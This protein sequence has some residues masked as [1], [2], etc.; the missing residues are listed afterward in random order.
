VDD[1]DYSERLASIARIVEVLTDRLAADQRERSW[2][3]GATASGSAAAPSPALINE[4][5][6]LAVRLLRDL[7]DG[8]SDL[9][10]A[11]RRLT[12]DASTTSGLASAAAVVTS[13]ACD[14]YRPGGVHGVHF[15]RSHEHAVA[16]VVDM[17]CE[18]IEQGRAV[19]LVATGLH[20]RWIEAQLHQRGTQLD[21]DT[22][23]ILD[24]ATTLSSLLVDGK[25][26]HDRFR[27]VIGT[28]VTDV[29][30]RAPAGLSVYGEMVGL[31]WERGDA[32]SAI[33]LE[34]LWNELQR[35]VPFSLLC[36]YLLDGRTSNID[37][38]PIRRLH[39]HV[40]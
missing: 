12:V 13:P 27:T 26:H 40:A 35:D 3:D 19:L 1:Q 8:S 39:S 31:L 10:Q 32:L 38:D 33:R 15:S 23:H 17:V 18:A 9:R 37:L 16:A 5:A 22:F 2:P 34:E 28:R 30:T 4:L 11:A 29:S 24:A 25:P 36:G 14:R 20:R 7:D 21:D 6:G